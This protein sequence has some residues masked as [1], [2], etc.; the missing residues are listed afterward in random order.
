MSETVVAVDRAMDI[1]LQLY[2]KGEEMEAA[3]ISRNLDLN[4]NIIHK[5][6]ATLEHKGFTYKNKE[7]QKHW[8]GMK[9]FA[10]GLFVGEKLSL[11]DYIKPYA[12]ELHNEFNAVINVSILDLN[13]KDGY[14]S[15]IILKESEKN[16][17]LTVN[18]NIGS[19]SDVYSS[20]VGKCLLA[21]KNDIDLNNL[22]KIKF[23][24]YTKNT[25]DNLDGLITELENVRNQGYSI[26]NEERE[27]GLYC[28]GAPILDKSGNAIA[29]IS[30]SG[31]TARMKNGDLNNKISS[32]VAVSKEI[33]SVVKQMH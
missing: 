31:P 17:V 26:D 1:L 7:N 24:K 4:E 11:N 21:F 12:K 2:N 25:I 9:I 28:I 5:T 10:M 27:I 14:R 29:S 6:L 23:K 30:M 13:V 33:S 22:S 20:S 18:P 15:V 32:L 3:E 8:L 16:K 19:S